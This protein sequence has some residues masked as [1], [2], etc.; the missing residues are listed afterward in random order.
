MR[1]GG[2]LRSSNLC[3][4]CR[5][6]SVRSRMRRLAPVSLDVTSSRCRIASSNRSRIDLLAARFSPLFGLL[7]GRVD[8][9]LMGFAVRLYFPNERWESSFLR[10]DGS[11]PASMAK[12]FWVTGVPD[13]KYLHLGMGPRAK[14]RERP[15]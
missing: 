13:F 5:F 15:L 2:S 10:A 14:R 3:C 12:L 6:S 1:A 7:C 11:Q 8:I 4:R 9:L